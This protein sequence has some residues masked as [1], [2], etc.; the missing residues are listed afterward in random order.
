MAS[1]DRWQV[2][3]CLR[4]DYGREVWVPVTM[5]YREKRTA[6]R[7]ADQLWLPV[8]VEKVQEDEEDE[9]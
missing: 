1:R 2:W 4:N 7:M 3:A 6:D 9:E 8:K 5:K